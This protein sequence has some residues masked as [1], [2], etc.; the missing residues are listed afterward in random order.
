MPN[1]NLGS[2]EGEIQIGYNGAGVQQARGD[3]EQLVR[4]VTGQELLVR[5]GGD[6]GRLSSALDAA[7]SDLA[8]LEGQP[9]SI[10]V[11]AQI[12]RARANIDTLENEIGR[13]NGVE[14][15][16]DADTGPAESRF[17]GLKGK[18]AVAGLAVGAALTAALSSAIERQ[19]ATAKLGAQMGLTADE[20]AKYGKLAGDLYANNFGGSMDE[21]N[22]AIKSIQV[23][24]DDLGNLTDSE[25]SGMA[26]SALGLASTFDVDVNDATRA[27]GQLMKT[28]LATDATQA[29][30]IIATGFQTGAN[31]S[32]DFLDTIN[33][34]SVQ[35]AKLGLD[36]QTATAL[37]SQG[38]Q[39]GARDGD[40]VADAFKEFSLRVI[41]GSKTTTEAF[42]AIGLDTDTMAD[43]FGKGGATAKE[44]LGQTLDALNAVKEPI[45]R[46]AAGV[47]LFGTQWEDMGGAIKSINLDEASQGFA[48]LDGTMQR[49]NDQM[50]DTAAAKIET[51]K[52]GFENMTTQLVAMDGPIGGVV[53]GFVSMGP[54]VLTAAA[55]FGTMA[56]VA[57]PAMIPML[58][59]LWGMI[60][61]TATWVAST[62]AGAAVTVATWIA[63]A[64]TAVA[65]AAI[66]AAAWLA[67]N[68]IA[69]IIIALAAIV[70]LV[71]YYWDE[72]VGFLEGIWE[73]IK[74]GL[75]IFGQAL[76][77]IFI[78][79]WVQMWDWITGWWNDLFGSFNTNGQTIGQIWSDMW[80]QVLDTLKAI[81]QGIVDF[82]TW[83]LSWLVD[84]N[85][86][87]LLSIGQIWD[88]IWNGIKSVFT[89]VID[90]ILS[91][92]GT[93]LDKLA[94]SANEGLQ[95]V[96][97]WF[98]NFGGWIL[99]AVGNLGNLL[100]NA[101]RDVVMG[102]WNG[103][104]GM[105]GWLRDSLWGWV[106][107]VIPGPVLDAL[108]IASPSKLFR[109]EVGKMIPAGIMVGIEANSSGMIASA[110][111]MSAELAAA[112]QAGL[113]MDGLALAGQ[114]TG[115]N[116]APMNAALQAGVGNLG[117]RSL[118]V[119]ALTLQVTGNLDPTNPVQWRGAVEQLREE[120]TNVEASYR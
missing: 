59:S 25:I 117:T 77:D 120:L 61:A 45:T 60:T 37:I 108:G 104:M 94:G 13:L 44:A 75:A 54:E 116:L 14:I 58:A 106:R 85:S 105:G 23:N 15:E 24:I 38:L 78:A 95:R 99:N 42:S 50:G 26:Q 6:I 3:V 57:V 87:E 66:I 9:H 30:D 110:K 90:W 118:N 79:P 49:V 33:E 67:A 64:A 31:A 76:Y 62:V 109:D 48:T 114:M 103:I 41:D 1:Y 72:I 17:E 63:T 21:V 119:G 52:R 56:A 68:P 8:Q 73:Y 4:T 16:V 84:T 91:F 65:N 98:R 22:T 70:A 32:D 10:L 113:D 96:V 115:P 81:W 43:K 88:N 39:G 19:D 2:V 47:K 92:F 112:A 69:L 40:L 93:S 46:N 107:S 12:E 18:A 34:Y 82:V 27:A 51:T 29:F 53:A 55:S 28:G 100:Y 20:A 101:G 35:F 5:V 102:I 89:G 80:N 97:G 74:Q 36:G 11:D 7:R 86:G 111:N 71:I 83:S